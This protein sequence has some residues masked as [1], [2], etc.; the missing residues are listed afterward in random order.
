MK[1]SILYFIILS[2]LLFCHKKQKALNSFG[3]A[4]ID[5]SYS[6]FKRVFEYDIKNN[7]TKF[8]EY[9]KGGFFI[10]EFKELNIEKNIV[11]KKVSVEFANGKLF[12]VDSEY[13][14]SLAQELHSDFD[15]LDPGQDRATIFETKSNKVFCAYSKQNMQLA[16]R[17]KYK[18][19]MI[20]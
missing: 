19:D 5:M 11:L 2:S 7:Q 10:L 6:E 3:K 13:N 12:C 20:P 14:K 4:R 15:T 1:K 18:P 8:F 9:A 17:D 16:N